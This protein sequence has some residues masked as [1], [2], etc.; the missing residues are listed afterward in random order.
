MVSSWLVLRK[1]ATYPPIQPFAWRRM[2]GTFAGFWVSVVMLVGTFSCTCQKNPAPREQSSHERERAGDT[3][4]AA[5]SLVFA[6]RTITDALVYD[7][8]QRWLQAQK[9]GDFDAFSHMYGASF[10]A[11]QRD[12]SGVRRLDRAAWLRDHQSRFQPD[13][14]VTAE[15]TRFAVGLVTASVLFEH[16]WGAKSAEAASAKELL[17]VL[18]EGQLLIAREEVLE[19][20]AIGA[21]DGKTARAVLTVDG[22]HYLVV[23]PG[24]ASQR[25]KLRRSEGVY[26]ALGVPEVPRD[27]NLWA[28]KP[29]RVLTSTGNICPALGQEQ[30]VLSHV[31]PHER[32]RAAW[33]AMQLSDSAIA[34][35]ML[36]SQ[37]S[38]HAVR[39]ATAPTL[40]CSGQWLLVQND[41]APPLA[42]A[43]SVRDRPLETEGMTAFRNLPQYRQLQQEYDQTAGGEITALRVW[44]DELVTRVFAEPTA[45]RHLVWV[46]A[47][48]A[49]NCRT[50]GEPSER[51]FDA[52][53]SVLFGVNSNGQFEAVVDS[54]LGR[55]V[56][57]AESLLAFADADEDG[58]L[59]VLYTEFATGDTVLRSHGGQPLQRLRA[60]LQHSPCGK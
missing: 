37:P 30:V 36:R 1:G 54:P 50:R 33:E 41:T 52:H 26:T 19:E 18:D 27:T 32:E 55:A 16:R 8:F 3:T 25:A 56:A 28:D 45:G 51:R 6:N 7:A 44:E 40:E 57:N 42:F 9:D 49:P 13:A 14:D 31:V 17:F 60:H 53:L 58:E 21:E 20:A 4:P 23:A 35:L 59:D 24:G 46:M 47:R 12:A 22:S 43:H 29:L 10:V 5:T 48:T 39:L 34:K 11:V 15:A 38:V 2:G